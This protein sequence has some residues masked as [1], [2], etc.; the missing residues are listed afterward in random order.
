MHESWSSSPQILAIQKDS[1]VQ[2]NDFDLCFQ[3]QG[4]YRYFQ[5]FCRYDQCWSPAPSRT[6]LQ[7]ALSSE[8]S[9]AIVWYHA[10]VLEEGGDGETHVWDLAV[11]AGG[12]LHHR[13]L[14]LQGSGQRQIKSHYSRTG[15]YCCLTLFWL[16]VDVDW[17]G[18]WGGL[19][20]SHGF[21]ES[22]TKWNT[23]LYYL[24]ISFYLVQSMKQ[25]FCTGCSLYLRAA[26]RVMFLK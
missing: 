21:T 8:L 25:S 22:M 19:W 20:Q 24:L 18:C 13:G 7:N 10:G 26:S 3:W 23:L 14:R 2:N 11:E 4:V 16:T 6:W 1:V 5:F 15:I 17:R 12:V 9:Q